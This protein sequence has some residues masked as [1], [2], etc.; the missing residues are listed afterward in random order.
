M[1]SKAAS[2]TAH[3]IGNAGSM[4]SKTISAAASGLGSAATM[5]ETGLKRTGGLISN[6]VAGASE[7]Y[8]GTQQERERARDLKIA[9]LETQLKDKAVTTTIGSPV[10][11]QP[12]QQPST[13]SQIA[14]KRKEEAATQQEILVSKNEKTQKKLRAILQALQEEKHKM[15]LQVKEQQ[16]QI[17]HLQEQQ[18]QPRQLTQ[19]PVIKNI[20]ERLRVARTLIKACTTELQNVPQYQFMVRQRFKNILEN[21]HLS[22]DDKLLQKASACHEVMQLYQNN[23]KQQHTNNA[24]INTNLTVQASPTKNYIT[25]QRDA[26]LKLIGK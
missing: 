9:N 12:P 16:I 17:K 2:A 23:Y 24:A 25:E 19:Q 26:L 11:S 3:G 18:Q 13:Q 22:K 5:L 4:A 10:T 15:Q 8:R 21:V 1:A 7:M 6:T 14:I 20:E